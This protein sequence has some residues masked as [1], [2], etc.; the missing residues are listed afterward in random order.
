MKEVIMKIF[1]KLKA[2][3]NLMRRLA[4]RETNLVEKLDWYFWR[5]VGYGYFVLMDFLANHQMLK[6]YWLRKIRFTKLNDI[7]IYQCPYCTR[8]IE[9]N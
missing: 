1:W 6:R 3:I 4:P 8:L 9:K 2:E 5:L 7:D